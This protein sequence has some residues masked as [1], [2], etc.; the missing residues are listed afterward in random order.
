MSET[1]RVAVVGSGPAGMYAIGHL[2]EE[3][4]LDVEIDLY[5]RLPTPWGLIRAGV[6]PDHPEKKL[7]ID[8]LFSYY[9]QRP[10]VRFIGNVEI[11]KDF[12][13]DELAEWYDAVIYAT[14]A[15][16]DTKLGIIGEDLPGSWGANEFVAW[17][18]GHPDYSHLDIDLSCER[19][20]IVGNG[21]VAL[22]VARILTIS[23]DVLATTDIADHALASL[24]NSKIKEVI[25]LGRRSQMQGAFHNP[26]LEELEH[27]DGVEVDIEV[28]N[29]PGQD[30]ELDGVNWEAQ[31]KVKT[32]ARLSNRSVND[33]DRKIVFRFLSS[34]IEIIGNSKVE[35][36]RVIRNYLE[37]DERGNLQARPSEEESLLNAGMLIKAIGYRGAPFPGLPFDER[38]GVIA[39]EDGRVKGAA[40][41]VP[42]AYVTGWIKRGPRGIIGTNK[43]CARNTV[44]HL[45]TDWKAGKLNRT[46]M[47]ADELM[48][49]LKQ[50]K[51]TMTT[52]RDWL[53]VD[54]SER[55]QGRMQNRPR[56]KRCQWQE[57][58]YG[59]THNDIETKIRDS[60]T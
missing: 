1:L 7:I 22:D 43:Q 36:I 40:G 17:Y 42:N 20:V 16:G 47:S 2:L 46:K 8:R 49:L 59:A 15:A 38:L 33:A 29:L 3:P 5:E 50:R 30:T 25:V 52:R 14:G 24:K 10:Q 32:L 57:L 58:L 31:R 4:N 21:N 51:S 37:Y 35:K 23:P 12:S 55:E 34:P 28:G 53:Q 6:A 9:L 26:E 11:G 18:N 56:V 19:A 54:R 39:N 13:H 27:L 48:A 60:W 45:L 41:I 44:H